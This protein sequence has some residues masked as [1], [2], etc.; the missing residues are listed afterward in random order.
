MKL[1]S[2]SSYEDEE[3]GEAVDVVIV[4]VDVE[5]G[6]DATTVVVVAGWVDWVVDWG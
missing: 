6:G 1:W 4:A 3:E 5:E 2:A